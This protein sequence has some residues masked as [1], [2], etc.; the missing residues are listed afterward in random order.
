VLSNHQKFSSQS[1]SSSETKKSYD[2]WS[3]TVLEVLA[4]LLL[5]GNCDFP[6]C[7]LSWQSVSVCSDVY[8]FLVSWLPQPLDNLWSGDCVVESHSFIDKDA[9]F[10]LLTDEPLI[11]NWIT[12]WWYIILISRRVWSEDMIWDLEKDKHERKYGKTWIRWN[13]KTSNVKRQRPRPPPHHHHVTDLRACS[14][15]STTS[16]FW[17][18]TSCMTHP[19]IHLLIGYDT[20]CGHSYLFRFV[21][22]SPS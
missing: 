6:W 15:T 8:A 3:T 7:E 17:L 21:E 11:L 4:V 1:I 10:R 18:A 20:S 12:V 13:V 22:R 2:C 14:L 19:L 9:R 16:L 5:L